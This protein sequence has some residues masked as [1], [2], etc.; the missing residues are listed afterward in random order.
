MKRFYLRIYKSYYVRHSTS[1]NFFLHYFTLLVVTTRMSA[2]CTVYT[3]V[4]MY[5]DNICV[6]CLLRECR[7]TE[8]QRVE[9]WIKKIKQKK[10]KSK[11]EITI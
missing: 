10:K 9:L 3:H 2:A 11:S 4:Y 7:E 6:L 8:E 1:H 5:I